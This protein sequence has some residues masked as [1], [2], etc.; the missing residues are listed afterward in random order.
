MKYWMLLAGLSL[1]AGC[2]SKPS[3]ERYNEFAPIRPL[4]PVVTGPATGSILNNRSGL[5]L[6][7]GQREWYVGDIVT[8]VLSE[9]TQASRNTNLS[10]E[11]VSENN[12]L[13]TRGPSELFPQTGFLG[14]ALPYLK[15]DGATV[16]TEGGGSTAQNASLQGV[17]TAMVTEVLPNGNLVVQGEKQLSMTEG[18]EF[19]QVRGIVRSTDIQMDN[20]VSSQRLPNAQIAYKG[21]GDLATSTQPG[22]LT[23]MLFKFWPL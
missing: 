3:L 16:K 13:G 19:I 4:Q 10:T 14:K 15:R 12:V 18:S 8:I 20:S 23:S 7:E 21:T 2:A 1:I 5:S 17:I 6:F 9:T 11:R 22:W